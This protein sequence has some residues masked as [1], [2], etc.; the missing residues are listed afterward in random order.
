MTSSPTSTGPATGAPRT[1]FW[2]WLL[3]LDLR[4]S[5]ERWLGGVAAGTADRLGVDPVLLRVVI[6]VVGLIGGAGLVFYAVAWLL[7][8]DRHDRIEAR[9]LVGGEVSAAAILALGLAAVATVVPAPWAWAVDGQVVNGGDVVALVVVGVVLAVAVTLLP[10]LVPASAGGIRPDGQ[11]AGPT[12]NLRVNLGAPRGAQRPAV[13]GWLTAVTLGLALLAGTATWLAARPEVLSS[14]GLGGWPALGA[15]GLSTPQLVALSAGAG[16]AVVALAL[17]VAGLAGRRGDGLGFWAFAGATTA[18]L[19]VTVPP[20]ADIRAVGDVDWR[21]VTITQAER[22]F[23]SWAGDSTLDL[24]ALA[25]APGATGSTVEVE[26]RHGVGDARVLVPAAA[27]VEVRT[28]G[29][30]GQVVARGDGWT[31]RG[32]GDGFFTST[33][34][35]ARSTT[36][37]GSASEPLRLVVDARTAI[38]QL[39]IVRS[40]A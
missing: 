19:A 27:D 31:T 26:L 28:G 30:I 22:G 5:D 33:T 10:K 3:R 6:V 14:L 40:A 18:L 17:L 11:P 36:T 34:S 1:A 20:T 9:A 16:T 35:T 23:A 12:G 32:R 21:P 29:L 2:D 15:G 7:L 13:P 24:R 37:T 8:P 25:D 39:E 38:G 4:R